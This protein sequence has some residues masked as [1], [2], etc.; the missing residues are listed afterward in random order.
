MEEE[1]QAKIL[2]NMKPRINY[3]EKNGKL[4]IQIS[5][6]GQGKGLY[7]TGIAV[8]DWNEEKEIC[9]D[10]QINEWMRST[11]DTLEK[12]F[13]PDMNAKRLWSSFINVQSEIKATIKD[14][15]EY[16]V[17][18]M[19]L[20]PNSQA[21]YVSVGRSL[22]RAGIYDLPLSQVTPAILR[23]FMNGLKIGPSSKFNSFVRVKA[24][25]QRYCTDHQLGIHIDFSG[26][27]RKPKY[28]P[29]TDQWLTLDEVQ[30]LLDTPLKWAKKDARDLFVLSCLSGMSMSDV[31]KFDPSTHLKLIKDQQYIV[32]NRVKTNSRCNVPVISQAKTLIEGRT[33]PVKMVP[34]SYQYNVSNLGEI[35]GRKLNTHMG[36][37]T[38]AALFLQFGFSMETTAKF[39]GHN[40]L[41]F[42]KIYSSISAQKIEN[43]IERVKE[44]GLAVFS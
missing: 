44:S 9:S 16:Y 30:T 18:T 25:I 15:F 43:E 14:A 39:L 37:K 19:N 7:E 31:L 28:V 20:K 21:V 33:W 32:F 12:S 22:L 11:R 40:I 41:I 5:I 13:R 23:A 27:I 42:S 2:S 3:R 35:I 36:R 10:Y 24:A 26:I 17:R 1:Q 4:I 6:H 29:K 8:T 38:A 34:R